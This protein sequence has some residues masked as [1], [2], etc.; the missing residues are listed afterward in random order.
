MFHFCPSRSAT[1]RDLSVD[2]D[3]G[4]VTCPACGESRGF[5]SEPLLVITGAS[6]VGKTTTYREVVGTVPA[7]L[8]EPDLY[9]LEPRGEVCEAWRGLYDVDRRAFHLLQFATIARSGRPVARSARSVRRSATREQSSDSRRQ[10]TSPPSTTSHLSAIQ[11]S[12]PAA[13]ARGPAGRT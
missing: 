13:S 2:H 6:G 3:H 12:K 7:V 5:R 4:T 1:R 9:W 10:T 8:V 11:T